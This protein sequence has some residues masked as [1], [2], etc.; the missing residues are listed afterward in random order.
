MLKYEEINS[1]LHPR[2]LLIFLHGYNGNLQDHSQILSWL[3]R[4]FPQDTIIAPQA[5]EICDKNPEKLQWFGMLK[6][7]KDNIRTQPQTNVSEIYAIYNQAFAEI[8]KRSEEINSFISEQQKLHNLTDSQTYIIGFS[9]GAML[10]IFSALSR[11]TKISGVFALSGLVA[12]AAELDKN[13]RSRPPVFLYHGEKDQKV[14]FKTAEFSLTWLTEHKIKASLQTYPELSHH[15]TES[16][17]KNIAEIISYS[18][19]HM[20]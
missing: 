5:P 4:Y 9:Q 14:Q 20:L 13:I 11:P 3:Q 12:A 16:E 17:I 8:N 2:N 6:Y 7:D 10:A 1:P 18:D 19:K 15:V